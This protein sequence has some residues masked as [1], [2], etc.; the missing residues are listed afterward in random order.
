MSLLTSAVY[1]I[2]SASIGLVSGRKNSRQGRSKQVTADQEEQTWQLR[3][4]KE[5][6]TY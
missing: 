3:N 1:K 6:K 5:G 4:K 2:T